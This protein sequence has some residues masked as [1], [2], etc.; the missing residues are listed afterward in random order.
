MKKVTFF[1]TAAAATALITSPV[2]AQDAVQPRAAA[3]TKAYKSKHHMN[4]AR[5]QTRDQA[6]VRTSQDGWNDRSDW[7]NRG[8]SDNRGSGF[9][10][11][12]VVGGAVG[13]AGAIASGA[14]NTAG[15]IATAPFGG[16]YRDNYAYRDNGYRDAYAFG[17]PVYADTYDY[18]GVAIPTSANYAA[19]NGFMCQP[20]TVFRGTNGQPTIC[21]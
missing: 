11:A 3:H 20:G 21:Q 15:T 10:P 5:M 6:Y 19:R 8:W 9:W 1:A 4:S 7:N 14:V 2:L 16:P 13:T 12:D 17:G 18:K